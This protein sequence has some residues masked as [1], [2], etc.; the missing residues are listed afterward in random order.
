MDMKYFTEYQQEKHDICEY[1]RRLYQR[2]LVGGNE[3]NLSFRIKNTVLVTPT[4][5]S[6]GCLVLEMILELN[7]HDGSLASPSDYRESS[8]TLLHISILKANTDLRCVIHAHPV[9]A[10][11]L[12]VIGDPIV[13]T[14]VPETQFFFGDEIPIAKYAHP[15]TQTLA[16]SV[17]PYVKKGCGALLENHGAV[18]WGK[19]LKEAFFAMETL[20]SYCQMYMLTKYLAN[21]QNHIPS[22]SIQI[23]NSIRTKVFKLDSEV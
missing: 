19:T 18:T 22:E 20:E 16:D 15:G 2:G 1:G 21:K 9:Y 23:I 3:G 10:T 11:A 17:L 13:A 4:M 6:K 5:E 7:L 14:L 12:A 8:E